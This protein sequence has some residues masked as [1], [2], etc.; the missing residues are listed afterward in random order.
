MQEEKVASPCR[1]LLLVDDEINILSSLKRLLRHDK[2]N[3][4]TANNGQEALAALHEQVVD[5]IVTDQRM[6]GMTGVDFLRLAKESHPDTVRIVLSGYTELQSVT[7]AV[8]EGAAYKFLTKPWDDIQL[9]GHVAEAFRRKEMADENRR[10]Q[11]QLHAANLALEKTNKELDTLLRKQE[12]RIENDE[13]SLKITHEILEYLAIPILG[14]DDHKTIVFI[15]SEAQNLLGNNSPLL[16]I[17]LEQGIPLLT[18]VWDRT[19]TEIRINDDRYKVLTHPM[20]RQSF[21]RG[22]LITLIKLNR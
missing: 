13:I 1:T 15:N 9:R 8:N 4:V 17:N 3:I 11:E 10:L 16:G 6:P 19:A 22:K 7:D 2:Y 12:E 18:L 14:I 21:S 20:G 5:V